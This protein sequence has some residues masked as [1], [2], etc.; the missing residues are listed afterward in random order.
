METSSGIIAPKPTKLTTLDEPVFTT[1]VFLIHYN[2]F[3]D[4]NFLFIFFFLCYFQM[5]RSLET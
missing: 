1:L 2:V 5:Q 4:N 3:F